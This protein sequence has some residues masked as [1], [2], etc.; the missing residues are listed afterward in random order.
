MPL[1]NLIIIG[2]M[3]CGT[4]SLHAYLRH[5]PQITMSRQKALDFFLDGGNGNWHRGVDWYARQFAA[6]T[7][8]RGE[9]SPNYTNLRRHPETPARMREVVPDATLVFM[10]RDP[11]DRLVSHWIHNV[12]HG[13]ERR[14]L[15]EAIRVDERYIDRSRYGHQVEEYLRHYPAEQ[16]RVLS[17]RELAASRRETLRRLFQSLGVD[18][19]FEH[20]A[21][22]QEH[23]RSSSKRKKTAAGAWLAAS[24]L[25]RAIDRLPPRWRVPARQALYRPLSRRIDPPVLD[26][27]DREWLSARLRPDTERLRHLTGRRFD[28]WSI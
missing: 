6:G 16:I 3:K 5:H 2:G 27:A 22:D 14:P 24:G 4:T 26:P 11:I 8:V 19:D 10:V 28:D 7:P 18:P 23:N 12:D 1:P 17:A 13:R 25:G 9:A 15:A 20:R 21:F